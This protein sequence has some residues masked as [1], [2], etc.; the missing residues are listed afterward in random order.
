[1]KFINKFLNISIV[2]GIGI[3]LN[4]CNQENL[5][6][7]TPELSLCATL[8]SNQDVTTR[9]DLTI[10]N[11]T[12]AD[13]NTPF[14]VEMECGNETQFGVYEVKEGY[15]AQLSSTESSKSLNWLS[16]TLDHT[17]YSWT[18]PWS[19]DYY[20]PGE[21]IRSRVS[22]NQDDEMYSHLSSN[23]N[24]NCRIL[25]T[26]IGSK[27]GPVNYRDNGEYVELQYQH[28]VSKIRIT[29][30][31]LIKADGTTDKT[32]TGTMTFLGMPQTALFDRRPTDGGAPVVIANNGV[33]DPRGVTY[34]IGGSGTPVF[35]VCPGVDYSDMEFKI[36][37]DNGNSVEGDYYGNFSNV[38]FDREEYYG[39]DED[40]LES[41]LYAGETMNLNLTLTQGHGVGVTITIIGWDM[42]ST[43]P[44]TSYSHPGIY[45]GSQA[46]AVSDTFSGSPT[47][48]EIKEIFDLYGDTF[49]GEKVF[50]I[51]EDIDFGQATFNMG[52]EYILDG[53]GHTVKMKPNNNSTSVR[54]GPCRD[55][56]LTDGENT[57]Y[58]DPDGNIFTVSSDGTKT[59][60]GGKLE[61]LGSNKNSYS[62]DLKTG[63]VT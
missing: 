31:I 51:Y 37:L 49:E 47:P 11:I 38:K 41:V 14:Y 5:D 34:N 20:T 1:M 25:E 27:A 61:P 21:E 48:E 18:L 8:V 40:K 53:M 16:P 13:F 55:I 36:H 6:L 54:I 57:V 35:Y 60:T 22:F 24:N 30:L 58:I 62:I 29:S 2:F 28:L 32:V 10:N 52:K 4:S 56:Y 9:S 46:Q 59:A 50:P 26:F 43:G 42:E 45:S 39:W 3:G 12:K 33:N 44:G 15:E 63:K 17:F 19:T 23:Q 7:S